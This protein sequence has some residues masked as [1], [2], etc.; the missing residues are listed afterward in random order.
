MFLIEKSSLLQEHPAI[1]TLLNR[2]EEFSTLQQNL[3]V[4]LGSGSFPR[5]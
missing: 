3:W 5:V 1:A 4:I 2:I